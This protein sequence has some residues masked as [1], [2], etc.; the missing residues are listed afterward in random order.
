MTYASVLDARRGIAELLAR[1]LA[2]LA[3]EDL[4]FVDA[5]VSRTLDKQEIAAAIRSRFKKKR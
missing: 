1:P 3:E 5:L 4:R 2:K